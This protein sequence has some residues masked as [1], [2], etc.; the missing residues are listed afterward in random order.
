METMVDPMIR[1]T[2]NT[3]DYVCVIEYRKETFAKVVDKYDLPYWYIVQIPN[4]SLTGH[5]T[6]KELRPATD[7]EVLKWRLTQ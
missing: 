5:F 7:A 2:F 6:E 4:S 1:T 3:G